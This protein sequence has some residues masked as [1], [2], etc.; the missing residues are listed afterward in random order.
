[1]DH[2]DCCA[3]RKFALGSTPRQICDGLR[4]VS[5]SGKFSETVFEN[6]TERRSRERTEKAT[7]F[8]TFLLLPITF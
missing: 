3:F 2:Y 8:H 7:T 4:G 1:M 6:D 5:G